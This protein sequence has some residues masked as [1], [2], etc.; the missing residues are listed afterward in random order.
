[1]YWAVESASISNFFDNELPTEF[2]SDDI[3]DLVG[4]SDGSISCLNQLWS[5]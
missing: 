5:P 1:M 4:L 2:D 3:A